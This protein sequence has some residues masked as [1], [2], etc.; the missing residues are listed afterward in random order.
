MFCTK[1]SDFSL[2]GNVLPFSKF[3]S[4]CGNH[5]HLSNSVIKWLTRSS[6]KCRPPTVLMCSAAR[7]WY[8]PLQTFTT[9]TSN[10]VPPNRYTSTKLLNITGGSYFDIV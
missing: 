4:P 2:T 9:L 8:I 5:A 7:I 6:V 3:S 10:D 1:L